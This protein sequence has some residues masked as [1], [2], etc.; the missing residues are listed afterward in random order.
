MDPA[1]DIVKSVSKAPRGGAVRGDAGF[2]S[3]PLD[4]PFIVMADLVPFYR[5]NGR[6]SFV[7]TILPPRGELML[8]FSLFL[9]N[10][11]AE[12]SERNSGR[13]TV[14]SSPSRLVAPGFPQRTRPRSL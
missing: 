8:R 10:K 6:F 9:F 12:N 14:F 4:F 5:T 11:T 13:F 2:Q 7:W 3:W 1:Y